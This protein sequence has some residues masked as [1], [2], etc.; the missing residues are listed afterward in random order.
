MPERIRDITGWVYSGM[1]SY[2]PEYP[3]A[4]VT[5]LPHP[6]FLPDDYP[7]YLQ[8][9]VIGG[10]TGTYIETRAHVDRS[11]TPVSE[12]DLSE[13]H[14]P[15]VVVDVGR[16]GPLEQ[17][18]VADLE[19]DSPDIRVGDAVILR[20]GWDAKWD[21][22]DY[23]ENSPFIARQ[24]AHWLIERRIGLLASDFP[25]FDYPPA[26]QFPWAEFWDKVGLILA[27]V[28]NL[29]GLSGRCGQLITFPLKIRG[30]CST[31]CRAAIVLSGD[32]A[33]T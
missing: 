5:Q 32:E 1:W 14:R 24:A 8:K 27:P 33:G 12:T 4:E 10:Q 16:K 31:P 15:A 13:F 17:V 30:A 7:A 3:G 18:T 21:D 22:A 28:V 25:R 20:T 11:A 2:C 19:K 9:F 29:D 26:M 23:V 6:A